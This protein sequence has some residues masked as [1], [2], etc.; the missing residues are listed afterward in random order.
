MRL[1]S[2]VNK[3]CVS[4]LLISCAFIS[5]CNQ[6][7]QPAVTHTVTFDTGCEIYVEPQQV[8]HGEK[9]VKPDNIERDGYTLNGWNYEGELWSFIGYVVT[10]DMTLV[11]DWSLNVYNITYEL[12]GRTNNPLNPS[13]YTVEDEIIL[14]D[15]SG[16]DFRGWALNGEL[17]A[18]IEKGTFGDLVLVAERYEYY[19]VYT[20]SYDDCT[21]GNVRGSGRYAYNSLVTIT[22]QPFGEN[23]FDGWYDENGVKQIEEL[24]FSFSMPRHDACYIAKFLDIPYTDDGI[25]KII[26]SNYDESSWHSH[27]SNFVKEVN[28]S[29][30]TIRY[31]QDDMSNGDMQNIGWCLASLKIGRNIVDGDAFKIKIKC[32]R[33]L[34]ISNESAVFN[35]SEKNGTMWSFTVPYRSLSSEYSELIIPFKAFY[36]CSGAYSRNPNKVFKSIDYMSFGVQMEFGTGTVSFK[37]LEIVSAADY[38]KEDTRV[39]DS[40]GLIENFENY[41]FDSEM[42]MIW[43]GYPAFTSI[44]RSFDSDNNTSAQFSFMNDSSAEYLIP[45]ST[46]NSFSGLSIWFK[47]EGYLSFDISIHINLSTDEMYSFSLEEFESDLDDK[48]WAWR[49][50]NIPFSDFSLCNEN[51]LNHAANPILSQNIAFVGFGLSSNEHISFEYVFAD[52]IYL[53]NETTYSMVVHE[54]I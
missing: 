15:P 30:L 31:S 46:V 42:H 43:N 34:E 29:E 13:T 49:E 23:V 40:S 53:N 54:E 20:G 12:D 4:C 36:S 5:G 24:T 51:E 22:A 50:F 44:Y 16:S 8:V 7:P 2:L 27:G 35:I 17:I 3:F 38:K 21:L 32:S 41:S 33:D 19:Y 47:R 14:Y 26:F 39:V 25:D 10:C 37:D 1:V 28:N 9:I 52:N 11:A 45:I 18:K 6:N 48:S